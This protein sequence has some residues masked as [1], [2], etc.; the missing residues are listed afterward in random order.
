MEF[1]YF[2][3]CGCGGALRV[4]NEA[5]EIK[6]GV[7]A[8][9]IR[10]VYHSFFVECIDCGNSTKKHESF[11]DAVSAWERGFSHVGENLQTKTCGCGSLT[12]IY[13]DGHGLIQFGCR[14]CGMRGPLRSNASDAIMGWN[15]IASRK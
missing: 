5:T 3:K 6:R 11:D 8:Q 7:P 14:S 1:K 2:G 4:G 12:N 15:D 13:E 10:I 9:V